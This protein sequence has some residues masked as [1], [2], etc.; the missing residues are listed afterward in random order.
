[1]TTLTI[2]FQQRLSD[3]NRIY[4]KLQAVFAEPES[5]LIRDAAIQRFEIAYELA[6]K[7][8]KLWLAGKDIDVRNAKDTLRAA[9][10]QGI[11]DD[12][13]AWARLHEMRNM[14]SHVYDEGVAQRVFFFMKMEGHQ[15]IAEALRRLRNL[16]PPS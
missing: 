2:R 9:L 14:T 10:E 12:G 15:L 6:W 11:I 8:M 5:E 16:P 1:M 3:F 13:N 7:T 4:E